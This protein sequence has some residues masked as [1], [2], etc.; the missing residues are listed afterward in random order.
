MTMDRKDSQSIAAAMDA[1]GDIVY[2]WDLVSDAVSWMGSEDRLFGAKEGPQLV[3]GEAFHGLINPEDLP[4]RLKSLSDH[5]LTHDT[6]DCEYRVRQ[7]DGDFCWVHD[8]GAAQFGSRGEP[9]RMLGVL[10]LVTQRK[11]HEAHLEQMANYDDLTG[12]FNRNRLRQSLQQMMVHSQRYGIPGAYLCVGIDKLSLVNGAYGYTTADAVIVAVGQ[13]LER[14]MRASDVM[15]RIGGDVF[16][17]V[18][19]HCPESELGTV[20]EKILRVFRDWP[21]H[22]PSGPIHVTV[23]IGALAFAA[24]VQTP[25]EAMTR[26]ESALQEAKRLGR[27]CVSIYRVTE[28]QRLQH[29]RFMAIGE[30]VKEAIR[31]DRLVFAYQPVVEQETYGVAFYECL[32]RMRAPDGSIVPAGEFVPIVERL[33]LTRLMD[34]RVLELAVNELIA[35]P[36]VRLAINI[37]GFTAADHGWLRSLMAMVGNRTDVA[38]RLIVEIT[39]TAAIQDIDETAR[40]VSTVRELGCRVALDDFGAG[41]TSFRHLK[42]LTVDIVK[43]DGSF[44]M[45]IASDEDNRVFVRTLVG[46]A[47]NLGLRTVAECIETY[48]DAAILTDIG[49]DWMQ[50]YY[51]ARPS[52]DRLWQRPDGGVSATARGMA[53]STSRSTN[54]DLITRPNPRLVSRA[55]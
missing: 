21:I 49:V 12:H 39:E 31:D 13:R 16:G 24:F 29:R 32:V 18:L 6:F 35:S 27:D 34:R 28:E 54:A 52:L 20:A 37:S 51:F 30:Q 22:T 44:I 33:G 4:Q 36:K 50:G 9:L 3:T 47:K 1:A 15:G 45:G 40:F 11:Q 5:Y 42:A 46:L 7:P 26:A 8:R 48:T 25:S 19:S 43:I 53:V 14:I 2:E 10:R 55:S 17:I 38:C 23:S 41:Y